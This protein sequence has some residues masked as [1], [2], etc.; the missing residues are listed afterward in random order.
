MMTN[1]IL[2]HVLKQRRTTS[3]LQRWRWSTARVHGFAGLGG[4]CTRLVRL[5]NAA[6]GPMLNTDIR[7]RASPDRVASGT[8]RLLTLTDWS[9]S[10]WIPV[11]A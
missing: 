8:D 5:I 2:S 3:L 4:F 1:D 9:R 6:G 11:V 10:V 7:F